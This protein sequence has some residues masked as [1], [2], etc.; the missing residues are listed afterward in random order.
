MV[1]L[2]MIIHP[3]VVRSGRGSLS[4]QD[5]GTPARGYPT[6]DPKFLITL[7]LALSILLI[8]ACKEKPK[9]APAPPPAVTVAEPLQ[10]SVTDYLELTGS[11]QAIMTVQLRARV[12]G[13]LEKVFFQDGQFVNEGQLL[14]LIQQNTYQDSLRQAEAAVSLQKA[15]L[16]YASAQFVRYSELFNRKAA[17]QSDVDNWRFQ[18][19]AAQANLT[20][21]EASRDLAKLNLEYTEVR[22]PFDGRIDRRLVDPGNLVGSGESTV[23]A[24][25]NKTN[26]IYAYFT[27]SDSD[28][29]RLMRE[30]KWSPGKTQ[31]EKWPVLMRVLNEKDY[32]H[33]GVVDFASISLTATT[34]TLQLRGIFPNPDG[35]IVPGVYAS[36]RVPVRTR[37]ALL[38]P[39]DA[40]ANDQQGSF[41]LVVNQS[42][43]VERRAVKTG[44][45]SDQLRIIDEGINAKE[46][47]VIKGL[48]KAIPGRTV[49][50]QKQ[51]LHETTAA[52]QSA[53]PP[54]TKVGQ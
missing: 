7:M 31:A 50:P 32:P 21:A 43:V 42:N 13:Y 2:K 5:P 17:S 46:W 48:Q 38:V 28:L 27:I 19:D 14:F 4:F 26:P 30:A 36:L 25:V 18:R 6:R 11:T 41:V 23:L 20:N 16:E 45:L 51:E 10:R 24:S 49:T 54:A 40:V 35:E 15:Q 29:A 33:R 39:Q 12:S 9:A 22:A 1:R 53:K 47:V 52:N 8:S 37:P 34:G 44:S 3:F